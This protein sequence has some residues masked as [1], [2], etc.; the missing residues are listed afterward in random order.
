MITSTTVKGLGITKRYSGKMVLEEIVLFGDTKV[1]RVTIKH[2]KK[3]IVSVIVGLRN[4][5]VI[6]IGIKINKANDIKIDIQEAY[7]MQYMIDLETLGNT[8]TAVIASVGIVKFDLR[9]DFEFDLAEMY[10]EVVDRESC[11]KAGLTMDVSTVEWWIKQGEK[12]KRIFDKRGVNLKTVLLEIRDY[13]RLWENKDAGVWSN[14]AN[15]DIPILENAYKLCDLEIPWKYHQVRCF[16]TLKSLY[17][18][19]TLENN[20]KHDA[21]SDAIYQAK[22]VCGAIGR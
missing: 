11:V 7:P 20:N 21:L 6:P 18:N 1:Y 12:A 14:G 2:L 5:V 22:Y 17:P 15:F 10:A 16:R 9:K 4:R 3:P 19:V 8:P 13:M